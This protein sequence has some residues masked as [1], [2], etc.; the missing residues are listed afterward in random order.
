MHDLNFA[1]LYGFTK[2]MAASIL[3]RVYKASPLK[4]LD[5]VI[6]IDRSHIFPEK[7]VSVA[8]PYIDHVD[9]V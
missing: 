6:C 5:S 2:N 4:L 1:R 3:F 8:T 7:K 9:G